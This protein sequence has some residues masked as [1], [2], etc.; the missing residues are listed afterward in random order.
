[1]KVYKFEIVCFDP[2]GD[3]DLGGM[4]YELKN[5]KYFC[6]QIHS[7][8]STEIGEWDDDLP[9]NKYSESKSFIQNAEWADEGL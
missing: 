3:C 6:T 8:Q 4:E 7:I 5:Q 2:N 9:I 1:M